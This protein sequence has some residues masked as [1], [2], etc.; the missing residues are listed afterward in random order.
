[1]TTLN[2]GSRNSGSNRNELDYRTSKHAHNGFGPTT[3]E[4]LI[5]PFGFNGSK[6]YGLNS[7]SLTKHLVKEDIRENWVPATNNF[8]SDSV[9]ST[10]FREMGTEPLFSRSMLAKIDKVALLYTSIGNSVVSKH[11]PERR[12]SQLIQSE[13]DEL[14][15][16]LSRLPDGWG[17]ESTIA[18]SSVVVDNC[19]TV[20]SEIRFSSMC[21]EAIVHDSGDV[22]LVWQDQDCR[23]CLSILENGE[24][25]AAIAPS[26][27]GLRARRFSGNE[28]GQL[29][30][31]LSS[32]ALKDFLRG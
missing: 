8:E 31:F 14:L 27:I 28:I 5:H 11:E 32:P 30:R 23:V 17:G 18:P 29:K 21:P 24:I 13:A 12:D 6:L 7:D 16:D 20:L 15:N 19:R 4:I 3:I 22:D 26:T 10:D 2:L 1:M 9:I 25:V